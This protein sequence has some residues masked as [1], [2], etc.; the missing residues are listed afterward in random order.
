MVNLRQLIHKHLLETLILKKSGEKGK[1]FAVSDLEDDRAA[2]S[3]TFKNKSAL[4]KGGF[5]WD[6]EV[7]AWGIDINKFEQAKATLTVINKKEMFIDKLED[8]QDFINKSDAPNKNALSDRISLFVDDLA[9]ATDEA[10]ADAKIKQYLN[11]FSK[12][13][14]HSFTNSFLIFI[15]RPDATRVAGFRQWEEKFHRKVKKGAKGIMIYAPIIKSVENDGNNLDKDVEDKVVRG[16]RAVYV[17]DVKD[18][19]PID[20]KGNLPEE[21]QWFDD[22]TP[23]ELADKLFEYAKQAAI[24]MGINVT[25]LDAKGG[26]KGYS[27]GEH[28]NLSSDVEG[29]GQF[30]TFIHELAHELMHWRTKS[31]FYDEENLKNNPGKELKELQAES[32]SYTVCRHYGLP[33]THHAT[34]LA[35]WR[36]NKEKI[37]NNIEIIIKVSK[38]II[39]KIDLIANS[40]TEPE[41]QINQDTN[42][43]PINEFTTTD[44][45][46][47]NPVLLTLPDRQ[48][49]DLNDVIGVSHPVFLEVEKVFDSWL[50]HYSQPGAP[51][52]YAEKYGEDGIVTKKGAILD[53]IEIIKEFIEI[54]R[55]G[56]T[57]WEDVYKNSDFE[58]AF[59][60]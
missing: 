29:V 54:E 36:A 30:A 49:F 21:P 56:K 7:N 4:A 57:D 26:E 25:K 41:K 16:Y 33:V 17:F 40:S 50:E 55:N 52:E 46:E 6:R 14:K 18:T 42:E 27:A 31:P 53:A 47:D 44:V 38:F 39:D 23:S 19:D 9:N 22:N 2:N 34:Y 20:E 11:F 35:L 59:E 13:R 37:K 58:S 3:E 60:A 51:G 1:L 48:I 5:V 45:M 12:F 8:I 28:I 32:V 15:Q 24:D 43:Q 10:A